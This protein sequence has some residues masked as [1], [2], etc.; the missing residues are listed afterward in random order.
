MDITTLAHADPP[1]KPARRARARAL[2]AALP[3]L[4]ALAL[5]AVAIGLFS[6][7]QFATPSLADNDGYYHMKMGW[8]MRQQGLTPNFIWL[9]LSILSASAFYDHH[10]LFHAYLG[11]FA[12]DGRPD[13]LIFGAK[14]ASVVMPAL[15]FVAIWWLLR[16]QRVRWAALW[17]LGLFGLSEAFLYRMSMPRAQSASLLL[18]ALGLHWLLQRRYWP[19]IPLGFVYVWLYNAFPLL[20]VLAGAVAL[21]TLMSERRLEWQGLACAALGIALGLVINLYFPND[22]MFIISHLAPKLGS[23][24]T[25]IGNEWYPYETWTLVN[26]S[27]VALAVW[28][29]GVLALGWHERRIDRATLAALL[30]SIAFGF[31]LLKSRRFIEYWP[32]FALIF[33]ALS[34]APL[35]ERWVAELGP[36]ARRA[37]A[38]TA[39][40]ALGA[41]LA[42]TLPPA[43]AA[44][45]GSPPS[46]TYA[47]ASQWLSE[48]SPAGSLVFQ[49]D[50]DDFPRLFFY[51]SANV[52][53][54][55]LDPTYMELYDPDLYDEWVRITRGK[56]DRP[57]AAI[58]SR[59]GA[60]FVLSDLRHTEFI[61]RAAADPRLREVYRDDYA[62]IFEVLP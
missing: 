34:S 41:A 58:A 29:L 36:R 7:V 30:L 14:L 48:N 18:L 4:S 52:Y 33:A 31:L 19:L 40:L 47:D 61:A 44:M 12:G 8:L 17:A 21:A 27:G 11:L 16:G 3:L 2:A 42:I 49:T 15:A 62:T 5:L 53:T 50:W 38:A 26:N 1:A 24:S 28:G 56:V 51:N 43:R 22:L 46:A 9:P 32:P 55:G 37:A 45:A 20:I 25:S 23:P 60:A 39:L 54:I 35:L 6:L 59:F 13:S 10:L 57:G